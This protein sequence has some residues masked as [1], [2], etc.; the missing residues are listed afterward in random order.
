M[1]KTKLTNWKTEITKVKFLAASKEF[2]AIYWPTSRLEVENLCLLWVTYR[3]Y[4]KFCVGSLAPSFGEGLT[5][6]SP[7]KTCLVRHAQ[8]IKMK[9]KIMD[10]VLKCPPDLHIRFLRLVLSVAISRTDWACAQVACTVS[11]M[12]GASGEGSCHPRTKIKE[13]SWSRLPSH[14]TQRCLPH[15]ALLIITGTNRTLNWQSN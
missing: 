14:D 11:L 4:L 2:K 9:L 8:E 3:G 7:L 1:R 13:A 15:C 10:F 6:N 5:D 12:L